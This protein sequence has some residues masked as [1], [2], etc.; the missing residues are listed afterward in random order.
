MV[1]AKLGRFSGMKDEK[2]INELKEFKRKKGYTYYDLSK[3]LDI[4]VATLERWFKTSRIN[5]MYADYVR[6]KLVL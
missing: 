5:R 1:V 2:L 6:K 4:Q 3:R